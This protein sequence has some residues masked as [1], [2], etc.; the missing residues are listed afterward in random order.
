MERCPACRA[1]LANADFCPRCGVDLT[2]SQRAER[3]AR[4][5]LCQAVRALA[6]GQPDRAAAAAGTASGLANSP[7]ARVLVRVSACV[8]AHT[9]TPPEEVSAQATWHTPE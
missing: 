3:Q 2:L 9:A 7:L 4:Q 5:W 1:R 8:A 6:A